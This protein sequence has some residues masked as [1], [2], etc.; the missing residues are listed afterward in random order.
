MK[1]NTFLMQRKFKKE[2]QK[3][4]FIKINKIKIEYSKYWIK[5]NRK[6]I[7][8][9]YILGTYTIYPS[10]M[11]NQKVIR[12]YFYLIT[13]EEVF[14]DVSYEKNSDIDE[15]LN[16]LR[17]ILQNSLILR[18]CTV[19]HWTYN[20]KNKNY[21][22]NKVYEYLK[23]KDDWFYYIYEE[24]KDF[25]NDL[26]GEKVNQSEYYKIDDSDLYEKEFKE[27]NGYE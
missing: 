1:I 11:L 7:P 3:D 2:V 14:I 13:N 8:K 6:Y 16:D 27:E 20:K 4:D 18:D 5:I 26:A 19:L 10:G 17:K 9:N 12:I 15:I 25:I 24:S 22:L 23:N 21:M